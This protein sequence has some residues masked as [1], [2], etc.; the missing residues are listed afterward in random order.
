MHAFAELI[1]TVPDFPQPGVL[2]RDVSPLLAD[3]RGFADCIAAVGG[4]WGGGSV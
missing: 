4:A 2:F 1:R 3:A